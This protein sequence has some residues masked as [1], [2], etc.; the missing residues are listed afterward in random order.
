MSASYRL[1]ALAT[2]LAVLAPVAA[3]AM[4]DYVRA[5]GSGPTLLKLCGTADP[6]LTPAACKDGG[7]D[8]LAT[9]IEK[10]FAATLTKAPAN[11]RPLL[12]RDQAWFGEIIVSAAESIPQSDDTDEREA[13]VKSLRQ[14]VTTLEEI[15]IGFGRSGIAGRWANAFGSVVATAGDGGAYHV[16][17]ETRSVYGTGSDGRKECQASALLRPEAN[18]WLTGTIAPE[19]AKPP[20]TTGDDAATADG[21]KSSLI[22]P[23]LIRIKRQGETLRVVAD[24][25]EWQETELA[26][27]DPS[28]I[29][30]SYFASGKTDA[31]VTTAAADSGFVAPSFDCARPATASEEEIC[32]DPD[33]AEN[34]QKLNRAWKAL[35]PRLDETTRR[36]LTVD[37]RGYVGAQANQYPQFLHP[38]WNKLHSD[39][40]WTGE[41]R[42]KLYRLQ[43]ERIALL[44]GFDA[45]RSGFVG[46]WLAHNAILEVKPSA[47]GSLT[48]RGWKWE[49]G[50]WKAG[51]DYE[52]KGRIL[53]GVF[54]S[55]EKRKNPDTLERDHAT[56]IVN[57]QDDV[58]AGKRGQSDGADDADEPKCKR[59]MTHSST[60]RL[61][62]ARPSPDIDNLGGSIR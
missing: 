50:D 60:V 54:R 15:A 39:I 58:F 6:P 9:Q 20:K 53:N 30:S 28:Q 40:H 23:P 41:A 24:D 12:K 34:D 48:A 13:F 59:N 19:N 10:A 37:Q 26:G 61:F 44:E 42:D 47:D 22:K 43:L 3:N 33:L 36:A 29:T 55:E 62:P 21:A 49:Q 56:L 38:A 35:L 17:I 16:A 31:A 14:R 52:I 8:T 57:R 7:F 2:A 25:R 32:A 4:D 5:F 11:V 51:C 45:K 18:G 46:V 27:C 1:A